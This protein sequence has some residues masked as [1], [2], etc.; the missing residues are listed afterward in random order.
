MARIFRLKGVSWAQ[1]KRPKHKRVPKKQRD[2]EDI[3][4]ACRRCTDQRGRFR[5]IE[6]ALADGWRR[7]ER[8]KWLAEPCSNHRGLCPFCRKHPEE[9]SS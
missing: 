8:W 2:H 9:E 4:L 5:S 1:P 7:I 6:H 3:G